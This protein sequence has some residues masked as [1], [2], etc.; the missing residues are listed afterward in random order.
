MP[1]EALRRQQQRVAL[2]RALARTPNSVARE[3]ILNL[4]TACERRSA[5]K[6]PI[7]VETGTTAIF[8]T[9]DNTKP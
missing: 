5:P 8:V 4:D 9:H 2:A 7:L 1:Y 6:L 3:P